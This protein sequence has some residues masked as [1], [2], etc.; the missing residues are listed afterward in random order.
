MKM[1]NS[2]SRINPIAQALFAGTICILA[3]AGIA[4]AEQTQ[5]GPPV[6]AVR[7]PLYVELSGT[8]YERG[9]QHG[10]ALKAEIAEAVRHWK[11]SLHEARQQDPD[12]VIA[13]FLRDTNFLPAIKAW[14][15][16]L[17]EE[18]KGIAEGSGQPFETM[19]AY[20]LVDEIW[21][22][23]DAPQ[24]VH[25]CS[26]LGI[27]RQLER[28]ALV[29]QN[30]DVE[31][32][33]DGSQTLLR[34][35]PA[36]GEP[37]QL[38]FT[39]AGLIA[40]NGMNSGSVAVGCNT[41][42]P[43]NASRDGLPVAFVVRGMLA[44]TEGHNVI[45]FLKRIKHASGQNYI[46]GIGDRVFDFEA[47]ATQVVRFQPVAGGS[48][49][50]HTNHPLANKDLKPWY[51]QLPYSSGNSDSRFDSLEQRLGLPDSDLSELAVKA[52]LRSKD[53]EQH[54]VCRPLGL[55]SASFTFGSV[56][57]TLSG[58]PTLQLTCGPP[59]AN[60]YVLYTFNGAPLPIA[61]K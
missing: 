2:C 11:D 43:L 8:G 22:Y 34:I 42:M 17:L 14:T 61:P 32:F 37:E 48:P 26:G 30:M 5:A 47:S 18:V 10:R 7:K 9:L 54:P 25:H 28:P 58:A 39:C 56:I 40:A 33:R 29:A 46:I 19:L 27:A 50:F 3:G 53:S 15:P 21:V 1:M 60:E 35:L 51:A 13:A 24:E 41:L 12:A 38:V 36:A 44:R 23:F 16:D 31:S 45:G 59:D 52:A 49:V 4:L 20:Q 57:M 55:G 6:A